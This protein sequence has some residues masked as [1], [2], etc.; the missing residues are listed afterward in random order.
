[1]RENFTEEQIK[2]ANRGGVSRPSSG[3]SLVASGSYRCRLTGLIEVS[4]CPEECLNFLKKNPEEN[5]NGDPALFE[6]SQK[7]PNNNVVF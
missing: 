5:F 4:P 1:M 7:L 2:N 3:T 6:L